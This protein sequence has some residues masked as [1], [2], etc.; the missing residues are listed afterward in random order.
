MQLFLQTTA[1]HMSDH[2]RAGVAALGL[3][4]PRELRLEHIEQA[5]GLKLRQLQ[6]EAVERT[7][8]ANA[9]LAARPERLRRALPLLEAC[10][11]LDLLDEPARHSDLAQSFP[12][13]WHERGGN[14]V[15]YCFST[16]L[17]RE[18]RGRAVVVPHPS[19][20]IGDGDVPT[21][22]AIVEAVALCRVD[23][24]PLVEWLCWSPGSPPFGAVFNA[25]LLEQLIE[26]LTRSSKSKKAAD[27]FANITFA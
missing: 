12:L 4:K 9:H 23:A 11:A 7:A 26:R 20:F 21:M 13:L 25:D 17:P 27:D 24:Q 15:G 1:L 14:G 16:P 3:T 22:D 6:R 8:R 10:R 5:R 2:L 18:L 19:D